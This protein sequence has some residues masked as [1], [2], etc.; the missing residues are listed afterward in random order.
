[1]EGRLRRDPWEGEMMNANVYDSLTIPGLGLD[2]LFAESANN[3][4][5]VYIDQIEVKGQ[6]RQI[7]EDDENSLSELAESIKVRGVLQPILIRPNP[8][9]KS[10]AAYELVA[11]LHSGIHRR[12]SRGCTV[13]GERTTQKLNADRRSQKITERFGQARLNRSGFAK[14]Q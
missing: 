1:M 10:R 8:N 11:G 7:F 14:A 13:R 4:S 3:F 9:S 2:S 12:G 6:I 5:L